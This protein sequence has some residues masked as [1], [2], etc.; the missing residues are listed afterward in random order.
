[1]IKILF[2]LLLLIIVGGLIALRYRK[3]IQLALY[4]LRMFLKMRQMNKTGD[5]QITAK[6]AANDSM[7]VRCAGCK[8]WISENKAVKIGSK[9]FYC[10]ADCMEKSFKPA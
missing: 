2:I 5:K 8:S 4:F 1:M 10:T 7:L 6:P 9:S 3:Q